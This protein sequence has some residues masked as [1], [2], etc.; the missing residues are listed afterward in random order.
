M[1]LKLIL[2]NVYGELLNIPVDVALFDNNKQLVKVTVPAGSAIITELRSGIYRLRLQSKTYHTVARFVTVSESDQELTIPLP[3]KASKVR[4]IIFPNYCDLPEAYRKLVDLTTYVELTDYAKAGL[5]NIL[6][7]TDV[8]VGLDNISSVIHIQGD[9]LL[10]VVPD[11]TLST[12]VSSQTFHGAP[13][14]L[15]EPPAGYKRACSFKTKDLYGNLQMTFF[16]G[17]D[18][19][20]DID[21]D[22]AAGLGHFFQVAKNSITGS[23]THPYNIHE[24]LVGYQNLNPGYRLYV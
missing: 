7:K 24:I 13:S 6:A 14:R 22:D 5:L 21:I 3:M 16:Q 18:W 11:T 4:S 2:T 8:T 1:A 12:I 17:V 15:H 20:A 23:P 10:A 19:L 9:R